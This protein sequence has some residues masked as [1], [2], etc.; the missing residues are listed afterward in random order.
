MLQDFL[1]KFYQ[2]FQFSSQWMTQSCKEVTNCPLN[3]LLNNVIKNV[4]KSAMFTFLFNNE[5]NRE[6]KQ[7]KYSNNLDIYIIEAKLFHS[8]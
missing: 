2:F 3:L 1:I 7:N 5:K 6:R 8:L 4:G